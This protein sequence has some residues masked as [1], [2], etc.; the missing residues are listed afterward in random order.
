MSGSDFITCTNS[1]F[2]SGT[3]PSGLVKVSACVQVE[4][5]CGGHN[6]TSG[7]SATALDSRPYHLTMVSYTIEIGSRL[8]TTLRRQGKLMQAGMNEQRS[9]ARKSAELL[10]VVSSM[11]S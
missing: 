9:G 6:F 3:I 2:I 5:E 8:G 7:P 11:I 4:C 1:R 10:V